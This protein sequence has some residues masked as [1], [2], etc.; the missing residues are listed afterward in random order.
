VEL[1]RRSD[2]VDVSG[3]LVSFGVDRWWLRNL[4]R[5]LPRRGFY[6]LLAREGGRM[7][8]ERPATIPRI[9]APR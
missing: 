1:V 7:L 8:R 6:A 9:W 4:A 2:L 5:E 3:G